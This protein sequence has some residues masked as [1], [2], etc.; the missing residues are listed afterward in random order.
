M[1]YA[2]ALQF[3]AS[4]LESYCFRFAMNHLTQVVQSQSFRSLDPGFLLDLV[5]KVAAA[6][7]FKT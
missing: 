6:G 1:L 7:G 5:T 4:E 3:S 2:T